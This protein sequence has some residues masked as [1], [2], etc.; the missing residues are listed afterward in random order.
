M[1]KTNLVVEF[2][3]GEDADKIRLI[4]HLIYVYEDTEIVAPAGFVSDGASIP[5]IFWRVIGPPFRGRYRDA[6]IIHD[7]LYSSGSFTRIET[8]KIF[9]QAMKE[10]GVSSWR[11][12]AM[13]RAVRIGGANSWQR[14]RKQTR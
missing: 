6:A 7:W 8:D 4:S 3:R 14:Y 5:R 2:L 9:M 12:G 1:F 13:Y 10:L 11:R